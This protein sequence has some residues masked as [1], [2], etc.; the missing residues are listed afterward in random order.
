[1]VDLTVALEVDPDRAG[2]ALQRWFLPAF[3]QPREER[4][5][6]VWHRDPP[7]TRHS[8]GTPK[9]VRGAGRAGFAV[10]S[11]SKFAGSLSVGGSVIASPRPGEDRAARPSATTTSAVR[12]RRATGSPSNL[13]EVELG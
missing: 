1:M 10:D 12:C 9:R 4:F 11:V 6:R 13:A 8:G 5:R 7:A 3:G 2:R